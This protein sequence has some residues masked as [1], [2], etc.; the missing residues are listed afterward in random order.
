MKLLKKESDL[1]HWSFSKSFDQKD[2]FGFIYCIKNMKSSQ[3]YIGKKQF[4]NQGRKSSKHYGKEMAWRTYTG[5][6]KWLNEDIVKLGKENFNFVIVDLYKTK[7]EMY[8]AEAYTQMCLGV[9]TRY[10]DPEKKVPT[11]YNRNIGA[12]RFLPK[13]PPSLKNETF[14]NS[15]KRQLGKS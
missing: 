15:M 10:V 12:V 8:Y 5:S 2:Y 11:F 13:S 7:G 6:S 14:I 9:M 1:G 4:R 3:Y